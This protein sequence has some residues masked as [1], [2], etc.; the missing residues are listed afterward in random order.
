MDSFLPRASS[1]PSAQPDESRLGRSSGKVMLDFLS[2]SVGETSSLEFCLMPLF[3]PPAIKLFS[4]LA[5]FGGTEDMGDT[6][7][8]GLFAG[9]EGCMAETVLIV[10]AVAR[11]MCAVS[12]SKVEGPPPHRRKYTLVNL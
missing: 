5:S 1:E 7:E 2:G 6:S 9:R 8:S 4:S 12:T 11:M 10:E 3:G